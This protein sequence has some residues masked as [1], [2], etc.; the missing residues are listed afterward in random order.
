[1][2][3]LMHR[4]GEWHFGR[5]LDASAST[6]SHDVTPSD[7]MTLP[8]ARRSTS[9]LGPGVRQTIGS[10]RGEVQAT[11]PARPG[12]TSPLAPSVPP[13]DLRQAPGDD[14]GR[15]V[16]AQPDAHRHSGHASA[17]MF[18][19]RPADLGADDTA[20]V[21]GRSTRCSARAARQPRGRSRCTRRRYGGFGD[22]AVG[23]V[24]S[25][26][27]RTCAARHRSMR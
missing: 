13:D 7:D 25:R 19:V 3:D 16:F 2:T 17:M 21:Q 9:R 1:M 24:G 23:Q 15:G 27:H 11:T 12:P 14:R 10:E 18:L 20:L 26:D 22:L 5:R 4:V 8:L 6:D